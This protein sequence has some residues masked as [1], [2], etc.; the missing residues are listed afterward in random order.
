MKVS[1]S[2][3]YREVTGT[4]TVNRSSVVAAMTRW[5]VPYDEG[6]PKG[7]VVDVMHLPAASLQWRE[8]Q[9]AREAKRRVAAP[10]ADESVRARLAAIEVRVDRLTDAQEAAIVRI[11][12]M[13]DKID[14]ACGLIEMIDPRLDEIRNAMQS[15]LNRPRLAA[16]SSPKATKRKGA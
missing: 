7:D 4:T 15:L 16:V 12:T 3:F 8:E 2:K 10:T 6:N 13:R 11:D 5:N 14:R 9:A 1:L